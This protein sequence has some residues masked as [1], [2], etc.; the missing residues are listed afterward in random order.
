MSDVL[1]LNGRVIDPANGLDEARDLLLRDGKIAE[2]ELPGGLKSVTAAETIDASGLVVAP[3]LVD[4]H[5][6]LREPGRLIKRRLL[7]ALPQLQRVDLPLWLPCRTRFRSMI[8]LPGWSGCCRQS[9]G[10]W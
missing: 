10:Q 9:V 5:V 6:H 3:G 7:L 2:V 4:V 1:I 8:L